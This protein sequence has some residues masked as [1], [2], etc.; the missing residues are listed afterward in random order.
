MKTQHTYTHHPT[1]PLSR[2]TL[3]HTHVH[4]LSTVYNKE[5]SMSILLRKLV[6]ITSHDLDGPGKRNSV[7]GYGWVW[8]VGM[9]GCILLLLLPLLLLCIKYSIVLLCSIV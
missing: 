9:G 2:H 5:V 7:N 3:T 6:P 4:T 1:Q 8:Y